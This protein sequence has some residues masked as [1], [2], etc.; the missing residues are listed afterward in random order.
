LSEDFVRKRASALLGEGRQ[1]QQR[2]DLERAIELYSKSLGVYPTAEAYTYRAWARA[3]GG[4]YEQAIVDCRAAIAVDPTLGNPYNDIG[5]YLVKL[6]RSDEAIEWLER[7][8]RAAR[9][10]TRHFPYMNLG[11][12]YALR[13]HLHRAISEFEGALRVRPDDPTCRRV[14]D[15][16]RAALN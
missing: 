1:L 9:Y 8:K 15:A 7:A 6:G 13:G 10:E 3:Q 12:L 5:S 14:L 2:G 11:R 4:G 16:L